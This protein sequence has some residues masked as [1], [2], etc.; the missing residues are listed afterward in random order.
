M[1]GAGNRNRMRP[2]PA[3]ACQ[4]A[5]AAGLPDS[6]HPPPT[7][8]SPLPGANDPQRRAAEQEASR[9]AKRAADALRQSRLQC[10]QAPVNQPTWTGRSGGAGLP[11]AGRSR[12]GATANP[13]LAAAAA[14]QEQAAAAAVAGMAGGGARRFGGAAPGPSGAGVAGGG[15]AAPRSAEILARLRERQAAAAQAASAAAAAAAADPAVEQAQLLAA[16][17]ASFLESRGGSAPS[18]EL[19]AHF[20]ASVGAA[21]LPVF[22]GVLKQVA[23]LQRQPGGG[24]AW[25]LKPEYGAAAAAVAAPG[26]S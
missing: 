22:R 11:P 17:V 16:Q 26:A 24:K 7:Q 6:S 3:C 1:P 14:Q 23:R 25:V 2:A 20:Q 21:Q 18:D 10:Q 13:R 19:V 9:I 4:S 8:P 5:A 12:F 15:G